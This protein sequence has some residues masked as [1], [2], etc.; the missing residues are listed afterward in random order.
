MR[1]IAGEVVVIPSGSEQIDSNVLIMLNE[2]GVIL[3][4][5]L[6]CGSSREDM[7]LAICNEY[8]VD[9]A[10]AGKDIDEFI[11]YISLKGIVIE[12]N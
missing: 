1:E 9:E 4:N 6:Y 12:E 2:T 8:D 5:S 11:E 3:W 10:T 7:I